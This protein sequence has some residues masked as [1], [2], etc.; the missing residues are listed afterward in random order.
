M[1]TPLQPVAHQS[2]HLLDRTD[3]HDERAAIAG[4]K[5]A[6][7][8]LTAL[9][10]NTELPTRPP[11]HRLG[12]LQVDHPAR[13]LRENLPKQGMTQLSTP[14]ANTTAARSLRD[15]V[16]SKT[17]AVVGSVSGTDEVRSGDRKSTMA[18]KRNSHRLVA[19]KC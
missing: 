16:A 1:H 17:D 4:G 2:L 5:G 15:A 12:H 19:V 13:T 7:I 6:V 3:G 10:N 11:E 8:S 14:T 9:C 18:L